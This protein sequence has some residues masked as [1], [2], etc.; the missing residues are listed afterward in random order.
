MS[1]ALSK[2]AALCQLQEIRPTARREIYFHIFHVNGASNM[3]T[4]TQVESTINKA[5]LL[6]FKTCA[7]IQ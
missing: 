2:D 3:K 7:N 1:K 6:H 5:N 4:G